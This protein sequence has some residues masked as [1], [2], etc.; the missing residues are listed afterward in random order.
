MLDSNASARSRWLLPGLGTLAV[1]LIILVIEFASITACGPWDPW[2]THYGEVARNIVVRGDPLDLWWRPGTGPD[3]NDE[4]VFYSKH[5]LPFWA[6]A[7]SLW[8]F[9]V[10]TSADPGE[11]VQGP[12]PEL[13]LRLPAVIVSLLA[14]AVAASVA[15]RMAGASAALTTALALATLPQLAIAGRQ[16]I[17]DPFFLAPFTVGLL[18]WVMATEGPRRELQSVGRGW[19]RISIDRATL[20]TAAVFI[21]V[22]VLPL[23]VLEAHVLSPYTHARVARFKGTNVPTTEHLRTISLVL[24]GYLALSGVVLVAIFRARDVREV[25]ALVLYAMAGV[26]LMGKGMLGPGILGAVVLLDLWVTGR[27]DRLLQVRLGLGV[28]LFI[29]TCVPWHHAMWLYRGERWAQELL[30]TH[31]LAR[32]ASGEH[33]QAVGS[34]SFYLRTLGLAALPWSAALIPAGAFALRRLARTRPTDPAPQPKAAERSRGEHEAGPTHARRDALLRVSAI[35]AIVAFAVIGYAAT[36]YHHYL[37]PVLPPLGLLIG[38]W[39]ASAWDGDEGEAGE[40]GALRFTALVVGLATLALVLRWVWVEPAALAHL[41]TYLY[42]GTWREGPST[43]A[44]PWLCVPFTLGLAAWALRR[45]R[46]GVAAMLLSGVLVTGWTMNDYLPRA[47]EEW[48][49]RTLF[50]TYFQRRARQD[51]IA[52]WWLYY[53][54]ETYFSKAKV[55]VMLE[56]DRAKLI[57]LIDSKRGQQ[58][59]IWFVTAPSHAKRLPSHLPVDLVSKLERVEENHH[60]VLFRL[61]VP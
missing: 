27:W 23:V 40:S 10:G 46:E 28:L 31:N 51:V 36:K 26:A 45:R 12:L 20:L 58:V 34:F 50:R 9:G 1:I 57:E 11:M 16:A 7:A 24:A 18:A 60:V 29:V 42:T 52:S 54:G 2:E 55:W 3:G 8:A 22:A 13:A 19:W 21:V 14:I 38:L 32:F 30:I 61:P 48:S 17:T 43:A 4:N 49:Q 56:P 6:M 25:W 39:L 47:S 53:R 33:P 41:T 5:A 44:L 37:L 59:A 15:R 35:A